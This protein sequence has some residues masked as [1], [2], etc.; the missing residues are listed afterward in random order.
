MLLRS[1]SAR[2]LVLTV[3]FVM[4][5][6]VL[7]FVPSVAR[8]RMTYFEDHIAAAHIATLALIA[9]PSG[10]L[11]Q[12]LMDELLAE[13][14]TH[15]ITL[16]RPSGTVQ[17]FDGPAQASPDVTIRL[18][19]GGNVGRMIERSFET[20]FNTGNRALLVVGM[21]PFE[22]D[23]VVEILL[24]EAP[25]RA[26]MWKFGGRIFRLSIILSL[27][28]AV[29]VY[30]SLQWLLVRPMRRITASM[31]LFSRDPEDASRVIVPRGGR[32]EIGS[33]EKEL[34]AMQETVRQALGQRAR[35][36]ALGTAVTKINHD[37]R[38]IL[39]TARLVTDGLT[40]STSAEVRRVA[41]RLIDAID[42]AI[43]L[44]SRT[45]DFSRDGAPPFSPSRFALRPLLEEVAQ[46]LPIATEKE[47]AVELA[48]PSELSV[49]AD[50]DQIYRV[51]LNLA[52]N[53]LEAGAR[54]LRI[55]AARGDGIIEVEIGDDG[56]GLAPRARENLFR[57]FAGSG[58]PGG[59]GLGLAIARELMRLHG[60][61]LTLVASTGAGTMFR[62]TIPAAAKPTIRLPAA[63]AEAAK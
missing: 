10:S 19:G 32:D 51:F 49:K 9:S 26:E 12:P 43:G 17:M 5:G 52:R 48:V 47:V 34:A 18:A 63:A 62:V 2:L 57:P 61:D 29:L 33:A 38:N 59:S 31:A 16:H 3:F 56:P 28:A 53:A 11:D 8:F 13:V 30:L 24:D 45:L 1:L 39:A 55:T 7:I 4:L 46:S 23:T 27:M 35:L 42:R 40:A 54:N 60:G 6:E 25:L 22:P 21:S 20:L 37:L 41:P 15:S 14:G 58:R 44:C 50:R 36:A